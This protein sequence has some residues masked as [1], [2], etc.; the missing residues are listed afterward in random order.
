MYVCMYVCVCVCACVYVCVLCTHTQTLTHARTHTHTHTHMYISQTWRPHGAVRAAVRAG[1]Q[2]PHRDGR[3]VQ[4]VAHGQ[5]LWPAPAFA[6]DLRC[7]AAS[8][9]LAMAAGAEE[10][11]CRARCGGS[12]RCG[13]GGAGCPAVSWRMRERAGERKGR[14]GGRERASESLS[15]RVLSNWQPCE[16]VAGK[17]Y[18]VIGGTQFMGRH[19]RCSCPC[20]P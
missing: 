3:G 9:P 19:V 20:E 14:E 12:A 5:P 17:E 15:A 16:R 10:T 18:L 11:R 6:V 2:Q 8:P 13:T 4:A 7:P 1:R